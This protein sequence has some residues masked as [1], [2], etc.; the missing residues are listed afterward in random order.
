MPML[1]GDF[2]NY[3]LDDVLEEARESHLKSPD[4][5][6]FG[7]A[8]R[9]VAECRAAMTTAEHIHGRLLGLLAEARKDVALALAADRPD[10]WY[11]MVREETV[12]WVA[13]VVSVVL[14]NQ[15]LPTIVPPTRGAAVAAARLAGADV[16]G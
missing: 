14:M 15:R 8:E 5:T 10:A 7:A 16:D 4:A 3:L 1:I 11:W 2:L 6:R 13:N 9:A 12:E